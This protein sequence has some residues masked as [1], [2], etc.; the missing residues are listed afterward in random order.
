V[1]AREAFLGEPQNWLAE[2]SRRDKRREPSVLPVQPRGRWERGA[3]G[4][5]D[6]T[7]KG[8]IV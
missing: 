3:K 2:V 5:G 7:P 6:F 4:R 8:E 1:N